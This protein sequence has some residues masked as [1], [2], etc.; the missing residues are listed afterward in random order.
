MTTE[1]VVAVAA[2]LLSL[3]SLIYGFSRDRGTETKELEH[4]LT[5]IETKVERLIHDNS[6][7]EQRMSTVETK[8]EVFWRNVGVDAARILH[9]PDPA[10]ARQD[11]LLERFMADDLTTSQLTE[12]VGRL[13]GIYDE[14]D[15][16]P[17]RRVAAAN[18]LRA[19]EYRYG[20]DV[21]VDL[22]M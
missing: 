6:G 9:S 1:V 17:G 19:I 11:F 15:A 14:H 4:R 18:L 22:M 2:V 16:D 8:V 3:I 13:R 7:N 10:L 12:L 20:I 21:G 5:A